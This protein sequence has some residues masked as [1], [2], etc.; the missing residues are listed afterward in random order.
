MKIYKSKAFLYYKPK[1]IRVGEIEIKPSDTDLI[2]KVLAC[3]RCGTDKTIY[4][5]GHY[6]VDKNA[7]IV[8]GHELVGEIVYVGKKVK[9]LKKGIG[10]KEGERLSS[11]Y[12]N[13]KI[14]E[15]VTVQSRIARYKNGLLM[16]DN[17]ITILSFYIDAGY[18]QYMKV[19]ADL[20]KSGSVLRV[21]EG[22]STEEALLVE[23]T[24]CVLESIFATPHPIGVDKEGRHIFSSGI[25]KGGK[26]CVIGSGTVSMIYA[27]L[28]KTEG[29]K[30]VYMVV[31]SKEKADLVGKVLGKDIITVISPSYKDKSI[32]IKE[33][34][35]DGL[36]KELLKKTDG[37]LFDDVI[38]ACPDSDSQ[39]LMLKLYNIYGYAVGAC[40]GGTHEK[41]DR[42]ELDINHYRTAKTIGTSGCST[43]TME[44]VLAWL[45][46]KKISLKG[47]TSK[48]KYTLDTNTDEFF[49]TDAGGLKPVL[50]PWD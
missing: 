12:L 15:R 39:R 8:L 38:S 4:Y 18:S 27:M 9:E 20:I 7:P 13:F 34:I 48:K 33:K 28:C 35:E 42:V 22:I 40:F 32:D 31:R 37:K 2:I 14:G 45:K 19:S 11:K 46:S 10:Y 3:G 6:K 41:A 1:D 26:A 5:K 50:Y 36:V 30:Q 44:T 25:K 16:L 17:P 47:F 43:K 24:A 21:S 29:A 23:P 49:T